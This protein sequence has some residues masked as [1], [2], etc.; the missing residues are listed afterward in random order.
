MI[1]VGVR[2][3]AR[4]RV[5]RIWL[6]LEGRFVETALGVLVAVGVLPLSVAVVASVPAYAII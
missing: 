6:G 4:V 1:R 3:S 2:A 5:S